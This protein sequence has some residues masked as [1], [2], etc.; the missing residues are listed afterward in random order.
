M[1]TPRAGARFPVRGFG[2]PP[3]FGQGGA[4]SDR[5]GPPSRGAVTRWRRLAPLAWTALIAWGSSGQWSAPTTR[6]R[7][8]PLLSSLSAWLSPEAVEAVHFSLRKA[9][10]VTEYAVLALLWAWA[11]GGWRRAIGLAMATAFLDEAHQSTTLTREGSAAD[12]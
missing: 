2:S 4:M 5:T 1:R 3:A 8:G 6:A 11:L 12:V 9:G 10:H 7:L